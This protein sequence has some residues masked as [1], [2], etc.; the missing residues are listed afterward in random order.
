V[1]RY[2]PF[3]E[4]L[5]TPERR[6]VYE[7]PMIRFSYD[8]HLHSETN[9]LTAILGAGS[10]AGA[11]EDDFHMFKRRKAEV[12]KEKINDDTNPRAH[13]SAVS[14]LKKPPLPSTKKVVYF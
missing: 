1:W 8:R 14:V 3:S 7:Y 13:S 5:W 6:S 10:E 4:K 12:E 11:D 9:S 2:Y